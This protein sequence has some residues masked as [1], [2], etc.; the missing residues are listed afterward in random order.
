MLIVFYVTETTPLANLQLTASDAS[1]WRSKTHT[2]IVWQSGLSEVSHR[3][4]CFFCPPQHV[5]SALFIARNAFSKRQ[6]GRCRVPYLAGVMHVKGIA[7][8]Q[9]D[10]AGL[11]CNLLG[12]SRQYSGWPW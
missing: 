3:I 11:D 1:F 10:L 6:P 9:V 7:M 8:L 2:F 12:E 5:C 4:R